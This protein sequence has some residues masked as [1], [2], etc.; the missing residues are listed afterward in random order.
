MFKGRSHIWAVR[1]LRIEKYIESSKIHDLGPIFGLNNESASFEIDNWAPPCGE[2]C[3]WVIPSLSNFSLPFEIN[4][5]DKSCDFLKCLFFIRCN[6]DIVIRM[7]SRKWKVTKC[8]PRSQCCGHEQTGGTDHVGD[9]HEKAQDRGQY[10]PIGKI[11]EI[12][13]ILPYR[14]Q[15]YF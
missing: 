2:I 7:I 13:S 9:D 4:W 11:L 6:E 12:I 8:P 15:K 3:D 5:N 10:D 14:C 1:V